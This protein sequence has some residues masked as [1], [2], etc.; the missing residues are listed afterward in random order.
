MP[1]VGQAISWPYKILAAFDNAV[2]QGY[3]TISDFEAEASMDYIFAN[4]IGYNTLKN[5]SLIE[6]ENCGDFNSDILSAEG[7]TLS[8]TEDMNS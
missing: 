6:I 8:F 5:L 7:N 1:D 2:R 4:N 3:A